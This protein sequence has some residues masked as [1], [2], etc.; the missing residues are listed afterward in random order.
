[1]L[2]EVPMKN[3]PSFPCEGP[4]TLPVRASSPA[5]A[6]ND[7]KQPVTRQELAKESAQLRDILADA[8][9]EIARLG[10]RVH[11]LE[12]QMREWKEHLL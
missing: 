1:M 3:L 12:R 7:G 2:T 4:D 11:E 8:Y 5:E 6:A 10:A 9:Q